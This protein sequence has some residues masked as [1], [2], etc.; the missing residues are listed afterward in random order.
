MPYIQ[1]SKKDIIIIIHNPGLLESEASISI[2]AAH[3]EDECIRRCLKVSDCQAMH[4]VYDIS[5]SPLWCWVL[6]INNNYNPATNIPS[7]DTS[8]TFDQMKTWL[9]GELADW[10]SLESDT[11][12]LDTYTYKLGTKRPSTIILKGIQNHILRK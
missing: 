7:D 3:L 4:L 10:D 1:L 2:E 12:F 5:G 11:S 8:I 6:E 9:N